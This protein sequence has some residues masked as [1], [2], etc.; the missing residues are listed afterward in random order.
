MRKNTSN[1]SLSVSAKNR[2]SS[3][4]QKTAGHI[5]LPIAYF[6]RKVLNIFRPFVFLHFHYQSDHELLNITYASDKSLVPKKPK[7]QKATKIAEDTGTN[8]A[9]L[10]I[11]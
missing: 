11:D 5:G 9:T 6:L 8:A 7:T 2:N 1:N 3:N 10:K 4:N